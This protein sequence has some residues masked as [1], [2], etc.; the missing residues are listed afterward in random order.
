VVGEIMDFRPFESLEFP[1]DN[2]KL[3]QPISHANLL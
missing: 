2:C 1:H 3:Y